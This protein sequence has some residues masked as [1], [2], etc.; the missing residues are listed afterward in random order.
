MTA[1]QM[2]GSSSLGR[3][4]SILKVRNFSLLWCSSI[5]SGLSENMS[6]I[7]LAWLVLKLTDSPFYVGLWAATR[8]VGMPLGIVIG[9][10]AD[11]LPRRNLLLAVKALMVAVAAGMLV[12]LSMD[13]IIIWPIFALTFIK[14]I[15]TAT[16]MPV[17]LPLIADVVSPK[18]LPNALPLS[19]MGQNA[20]S[21][22]GP[23]LGGLLFALLGPRNS[24][25]VVLALICI[26]ILAILLM[27]PV[28]QRS[29]PRGESPLR[30]ILMGIA[31]V[32]RND[33][34]LGILLLI[35]GFNLTT[36]IL[37]FTLMPVFAK[38]VLGTDAKGLGFL[39]L[40]MGVGAI[41]GST[42]MAFLSRMQY[43]STGF[44]LW[45]NVFWNALIIL[46]SVTSL[47]TYSFGLAALI[48]VFIGLCQN[49][50]MVGPHLVLLRESDP[51]FRGRVI[52]LRSAAITPLA[53]S[54]LYGGALA[55]LLGTPMALIIIC[56]AGILLTGVLAFGL[57]GM[58]RRI[59][60]PE[61]GR[62]QSAETTV[63]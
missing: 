11:R 5:F 43:L 27:R 28:E 42:V 63:P 24:Y 50:M 30:A 4:V 45:T 14:G 18:Q 53:L 35:V 48:L 9:S 32:R 10:L 58:W 60:H 47:L 2:T 13:K 39:M 34:L 26:G 33:V 17:Q 25:A 31:H 44:L 46:L 56:L 52:G 7:I 23:F 20:T 54:S 21:L 16:L 49:T 38:D 55:E 41:I 37:S 22:F 3:L 57:P 15:F 1:S 6:A 59:P 61:T 29:A 8:F 19:T 40:M 12:L 36:L 51:E 62:A